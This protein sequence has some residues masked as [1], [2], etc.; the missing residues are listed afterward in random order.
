MTTEQVNAEKQMLLQVLNQEGMFYV[1]NITRWSARASIKPAELNLPKQVNK[2]LLALGS[3]KLMLKEHTDE[4]EKCQRDAYDVLKNG[5]YTQPFF[6][7]R[8]VRA[9]HVTSI[10]RELT[11]MKAKFFMAV[12]TF[13]SRYSENVEEMRGLWVE[14]L[15]NLYPNQEALRRSVLT[16]IM[17]CYPEAIDVRQKFTFDWV[18]FAFALPDTKLAANVAN[19][20]EVQET[21]KAIERMQGKMQEQLEAMVRRDASNLEKAIQELCSSV[22]DTSESSPSGLHQKTIDRIKKEIDTLRQINYANVP[23][24]NLALKQLES[25][26]SEKAVDIRKRDGVQDFRDTVANIKSQIEVALEEDKEE[27]LRGFIKTGRRKI[28]TPF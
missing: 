15:E 24:V 11:E 13:M 5:E 20:R 17:S 19:A 22:L 3:K 1:L 12:D 25:L 14:E 8:F 9:Q 27:T 4:I 10:E 7:M 21:S 18:A 2:K 28:E 6:G 16:S 26:T 23:S